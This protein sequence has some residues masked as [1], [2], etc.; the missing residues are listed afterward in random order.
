MSQ[1][2][3]LDIEEAAVRLSSTPQAV[4]SLIKEGV[5][6]AR[7]FDGTEFVVRSD[8]IESLADVFSV[9]ETR[10]RRI[11]LR[12]ARASRTPHKR[13]PNKSSET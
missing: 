5:L 7:T 13:N 11:Y 4:E 2:C 12:K 8:E 3:W 6:S 10:Q 9:S 1:Y